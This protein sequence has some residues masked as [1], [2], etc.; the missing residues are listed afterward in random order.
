MAPLM[1][2]LKKMP[3]PTPATPCNA[4]DHHSYA[5]IPSRGIAGAELTSWE[6]FSSSVSL[7]TK[8]L[9]LWLMGSVVLQKGKVSVDGFDGSHENRG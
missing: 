2:P 5:G 6:I 9:A 7:E 3:F 8:S 4:S 1:V